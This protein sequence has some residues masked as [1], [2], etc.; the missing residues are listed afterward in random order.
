MYADGKMARLRKRGVLVAL[1]LA[2][3]S[4][5]L[6]GCG[7]SKII[8]SGGSATGL[9]GLI[10][11][12]PTPV[13]TVTL[14]QT[15]TSRPTLTPTM[16]E[17]E[18]PTLT[19][20]STITST[21]SPTPTITNTPTSTG[22]PFPSLEAFA[23]SVR[24]AGMMGIWSDG[25]FA[26]RAYVGGWGDVPKR[27]NTASYASYNGY[28]AFFIHDYEG[29]SE[30]YDVGGGAKVAVISAGGIR[31]YA[32]NSSNW[33]RGSPNGVYC[34]YKEP[35]HLS[36]GQEISDDGIL[37]ANY[38]KPFVIQ[39]CYCEGSVGGILVLT[40]SETNGPGN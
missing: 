35:F 6:Y 18:I 11:D 31:W 20:T 25:L 17:T 14:E 29:G 21:P 15:A 36:G 7:F 32:I 5:T 13:Y 1:G 39:T 26:Y 27:W 16:T 34:G 12:S 37:E 4:L 8:S 9:E 33:Y 28:S 3:A 10:L 40:G 19:P 30:L 24:S 38:T 23:E 22:I 2:A